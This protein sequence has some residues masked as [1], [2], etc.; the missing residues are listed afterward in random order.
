MDQAMDFEGHLRTI[1]ELNEVIRR[2]DFPQQVTIDENRHVE[3][4]VRIAER[5]AARVPIVRLV[6]VAGP[7]SAGKTTTAIRLCTRLNENGLNALRLSTDD[8]FVDGD[9]NPLDEN[10][11]PDWETVE[12]LDR[13]R[14][15]ADLT[16]LLSGEAVRLR[17]FDFVRHVGYEDAE[18]SRLANGGVVVLEGIHALNPLLTDGVSEALKF[19]VYL[20]VFTFLRPAPTEVFFAEDCRLIRRIV[21]DCANRGMSPSDTIARWPSVEAGE[22]RWINPFRRLA[23]AVFNTSLDYELAVLRPFALDLLRGVDEADPGHAQAS[24]LAGVLA[25]VTEAPTVGV[26]GNSII[27]ETIGDSTLRY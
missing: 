5:I 22:Q 23:D 18:P 11:M 15:V 17:R 25:S 8:Y 24:R 4:I 9:L 6:L 10:G 7:S 3:R 13:R 1:D 14:L 27:R 12:A 26:P 20:N 16:S 21:R 19:R 2:G